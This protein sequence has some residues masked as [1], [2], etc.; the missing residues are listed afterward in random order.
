[1]SASFAIALASEE[2]LGPRE[3]SAR[4]FHIPTAVMSKPAVATPVAHARLLAIARLSSTAVTCI[5]PS[6]ARTKIRMAELIP[7]LSIETVFSGALRL[8]S[9]DHRMS[10]HAG[11]ENKG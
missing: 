7:K 1:M 8:Y 3:L 10:A 9:V 6:S 4:A 2:P 11:L 5:A